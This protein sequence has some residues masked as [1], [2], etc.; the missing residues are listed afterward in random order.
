VVYCPHPIEFINPIVQEFEV[1]TG[2]KVEVVTAGTGE[3]LTRI[4]SEKNDP[5]GDVMWGGGR[6]SMETYKPF[7]EPYSS[8]NRPYL[9]AQYLDAGDFYSPFT[10]MPTVFMYNTN[11]ML[12]DE[13]PKAW[14][15]LLNPKWKGRIA[16]ADPAKSSSSFEALVTMLFAMGY[17]LP[18]N[19]WGYA[20]QF[21]ANLDGKILS[22]S[23]TVYRGVADG[24]Y[25]LGVTFEEPVAN[26][27]KQG[28]P[29]GIVYPS[30]GTVVEADGVAVI[31]GSKNSKNAR[32]FV[33]FV[34][35]KKVQ[36]KIAK[37]LDRRSCR[38]D[39]PP[40][41]GLLDLGSMRVI[42]GDFKW[43]GTN[44]AALLERFKE[45]FDHFISH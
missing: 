45:S 39:V 28:A 3:L 2:V 6:A 16:F 11:L 44:K 10:I 24:E 43:A 12:A 15:D 35:S 33:D 26:Y 14:A 30:E 7:F 13:A 23:S 17:G 18:D 20:R 42:P 38:R 27:L 21:I 41:T 29:V 31:K 9:M 32:L 36:T 37:D 1:E 8:V 40:A 25:E 19:G 4:K 34:T 5:R 22:G